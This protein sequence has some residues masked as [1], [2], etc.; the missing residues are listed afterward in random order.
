MRA[1]KPNN[2]FEVLFSRV[3]WTFFFVAFFFRFF[4]AGLCVIEK[5]LGTKRYDL[6]EKKKENHQ[7]TIERIT[8]KK[9]HFLDY[10]WE[11]KTFV[12]M[13]KKC[14][15]RQLNKGE[16][17]QAIT[18]VGKKKKVRVL[19]FMLAI[20]LLMVSNI[21]QAFSFRRVLTV[22]INFA[23]KLFYFWAKF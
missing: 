22:K 2:F 20:L 10:Y 3:V 8:Q 4:F 5:F 6:A 21:L 18:K 13:Y 11:K 19:L 17:P 16:D 23:K 1:W 9:G 15:L 14:G 7:Q 12:D